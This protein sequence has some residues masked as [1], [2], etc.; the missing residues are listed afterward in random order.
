MIANIYS[1]AISVD[2]TQQP[3]EKPV[4]V[5]KPLEEEQILT[6]SYLGLYKSVAGNLLNSVYA[7]KYCQYFTFQYQ[8]VFQTCF[9]IL[10]NSV[11]TLCLSLNTLDSCHQLM[12]KDFKS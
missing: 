1:F 9:W 3:L 7:G 8:L 11:Y 5:F 10:H 6:V 4:F 2:I 12:Y